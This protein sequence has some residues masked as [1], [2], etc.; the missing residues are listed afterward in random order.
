MTQHQDWT[1][2]RVETLKARWAQGWSAGEIM[3]VL[4]F[5]RNAIL[6]KVDRLGLTRDKGV[7]KPP[8]QRPSKLARK[9]EAKRV[10]AAP[11]EAAIELPP[12]EEP[13]DGVG[14]AL[15]DLTNATCRWPKGVPGDDDF[16]FC[17]DPTAD[18]R[19]GKP[20]CPF[21]AARARR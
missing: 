17:G 7:R 18:M 5:S 3:A 8:A 4:P 1:P 6:G 9:P 12:T 13:S 15:F 20:Y 2:E 16:L 14:V 10:K 19:S 21:H 11:I